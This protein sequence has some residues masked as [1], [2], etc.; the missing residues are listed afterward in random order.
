MK[1]HW[2]CGDVYLDGY[3]NLDIKGVL[4]HTLKLREN[5]NRTTLE[6]YYKRPFSNNFEERQR[7]DFIV[8]KQL[9]ILQPWPFEDDSINKIVMISCWEHFFSWQ[10]PFIVREVERVLKKDGRL[11]VD[12]PD[13]KKDIELYYDSN[14][15]YLMELIYCNGK[16]DL[17]VHKW[18]YT[19]KSFAALWGEDFIV[20]EKTIVQHD[21]PMIGMEVIKK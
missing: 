6:N 9:D 18:G 15:E 13:I 1:L 19:A 8:D 7:G 16:D 3:L 2:C 12:F 20:H 14:P 5:P 4:A 11:I 17:S 10:I 21:Y